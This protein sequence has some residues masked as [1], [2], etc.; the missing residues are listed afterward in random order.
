MKKNVRNVEIQ[1]T[2]TNLIIVYVRSALLD[3]ILQMTRSNKN[4]TKKYYLKK[5]FKVI[6]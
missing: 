6:L 2:L 4:T 1:S 3:F 5:S